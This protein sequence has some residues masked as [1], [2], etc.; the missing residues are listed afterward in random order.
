MKVSII[1]HLADRT[2]FSQK[3]KSKRL[4]IDTSQDEGYRGINSVKHVIKLFIQKWQKEN[5]DWDCTLL[6][7]KVQYKGQPVKR[8]PKPM[9]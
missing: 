4:V 5:Q 8:I 3:G 9:K 1:Y 2:T 7:E 6:I